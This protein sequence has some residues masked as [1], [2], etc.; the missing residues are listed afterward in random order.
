MGI[1]SETENSKIEFR[2][3]LL[4]STILKWSFIYDENVTVVRDLKDRRLSSIR[5][6]PA[7]APGDSGCVKLLSKNV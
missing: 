2:N 7:A 4:Y 1:I 5:S 3:E 6:L